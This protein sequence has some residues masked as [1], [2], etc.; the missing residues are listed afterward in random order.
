M[1]AHKKI[2]VT[3]AAGRIGSF[4]VENL[5]E[6]YEFV[7]TDIR[8]IQNTHG[9]PFIQA[10]IKDLESV[11][12]LCR[13]VETVVHLAANP[14]EKALWEEIYPDNI[15]GVYN[16]FQAAVDSQC[17]RVIFASSI[18][19]VDGYPAEIQVTPQMPVRPPNIYGAAKAW[20]EALARYY[21]DQKSISMICLRIGWVVHRD[22]P[23]IKPHHPSLNKIITFDD[24]TKL[25]S[26]CIEAPD[27]LRFG[28]FHGISDNRIKRLDISNACEELGYKPSDDAFSIAEERFKMREL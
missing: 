25:V 9:F 11:R 15:I 14:N 8:Q 13:G 24:L 1:K 22:N 23:N 4:L 2:L 7:L 3:G 26:A 20:G 21:A 12:R 16:V 28:I 5:S 19:A 10:D 6:R 27:D 18:H 17:K